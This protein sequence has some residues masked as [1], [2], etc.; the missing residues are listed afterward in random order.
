MQLKSRT[1]RE[2]YYIRQKVDV[3]FLDVD[4][5]RPVNLSYDMERSNSNMVGNF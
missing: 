2:R 3:L 4:I 5:M 1:K